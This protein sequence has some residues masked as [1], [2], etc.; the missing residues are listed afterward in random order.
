MPSSLRL[1]PAHPA[2]LNALHQL[3]EPLLS[4]LDGMTFHALFEPEDV[5]GLPPGLDGT[6]CRKALLNIHQALPKPLRAYEYVVEDECEFAGA[7]GDPLGGDSGHIGL[8]GALVDQVDIDTLTGFHQHCLQA[9]AHADGY[10]GLY[11]LLEEAGDWYGS[12][13]GLR[14]ETPAE[15]TDR[16][17][18]VLGVLNV[19]DDDSRTLLRA[20]AACPDPARLVL[21]PAEEEAATRFLLRIDGPATEGIPNAT[22][23]ATDPG[24]GSRANELGVPLGQ[25]PVDAVG[26]LNG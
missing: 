9:L 1:L 12:E 17:R 2:F 26:R 4:W 24:D 14:P 8:Y 3:E 5:W 10:E 23:A 15:V 16:V 11:T 25:H 21:A 18:R 7:A 6:A 20:L 22:A 19:D 13:Y